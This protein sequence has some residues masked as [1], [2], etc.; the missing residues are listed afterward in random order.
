MWQM[1]VSAR[2]KTLAL[3]LLWVAEAAVSLI[4]VLSILNNYQILLLF[5]VH[6]PNIIS[7]HCLIEFS[8]VSTVVR[9]VL[10]GNAED[11]SFSNYKWKSSFKDEYINNI[12]TEYFQEQL[13]TLVDVVDDASCANDIDVSISAFSDLMHN[14]CDALFAQT[15]HTKTA[16]NIKENTAQYMFDNTCSERRKTFFRFFLIF[17]EKIKKMKIEQIW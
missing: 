14:V 17:F 9:Q 13:K 10:D 1:G 3:S 8:L 12:S 11:A 16:N 15:K 4:I 2:I 7:D 5:N 6:D